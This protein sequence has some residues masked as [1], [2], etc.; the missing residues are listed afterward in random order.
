MSGADALGFEWTERVRASPRPY[1]LLL[2]GLTG[3]GKTQ[4]ARTLER[5]LPA[6]RF[7]MDDWMIALFGEHLPR[8]THDQRF[9]QLT[10]IAWDTAER[11]LAL[12]VHVILDYGFWRRAQRLETAQRVR[13]AGALPLLVY[14]DV[15]HAA[16]ER[17][18]AARNAV[19]P[20]GSYLITPE[21]LELFTGWF[22]PPDEDEGIELVRLGP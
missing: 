10:A 5:E 1:V 17:R 3:S 7:N 13:E 16:L 15:P 18:L 21:M 11:A 9:A 8:E 2:C 4:L 14:L 19:H 6:L 12:G 22:E 20:A